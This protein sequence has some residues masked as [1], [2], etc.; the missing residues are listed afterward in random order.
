VTHPLLKVVEEH[1]EWLRWR[2]GTLVLIK[3]PY[4]NETKALFGDQHVIISAI[5]N[6]ST[7]LITGTKEKIEEYWNNHI[8]ES[9][10]TYFR[11]MRNFF[12]ADQD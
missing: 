10:R 2:G 5:K 1:P 12:N 7:R 9:Q 11:E 3:V 6:G 4:N 8:P